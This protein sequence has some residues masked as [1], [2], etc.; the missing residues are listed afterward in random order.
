MSNPDAAAPAWRGDLAR[1]LSLAA[2]LLLGLFVVAI[3]VQPQLASVS[4]EAGLSV[5]LGLLFV[6]TAF[7]ARAARGEAAS[8]PSERLCLALC[9]WFGLTLLGLLRTQHAGEAVPQALNFFL[10]GLLL[11]GAHAFTAAQPAAQVCVARAVVALGAVEALYGLSMLKIQLPRLREQIAAGTLSLRDEMTSRLAQDRFH[12][13]EIY[14]S[15]EIANSF[16]AF[17]LVTIFVQLGLWLDERRNRQ[18]TVEGERPP[19]VTG[20]DVLYTGVLLLQLAALCQSGSKGAWVAALLG[21]WFFAAQALARDARRAKILAALT[22]C[23]VAALA[24]VLVLMTAGVLGASLL[25]ES[26]SMRIEYWRTA[27]RMVSAE[28]VLGIGLGSFGDT[29]TFFKTPLATETRQA[30][31]DWLQLWAE[32]GVLGPLAWGVLWWTALRPA[33]AKQTADRSPAEPSPDIGKLRFA[34]FAAGLAAFVLVYAVFD[35]LGSNDLWDTLAGHGDAYSPLGVAV[36]LL[37]P[38]LFTVVCVFPRKSRDSKTD[39]SATGL[40]WGIRAAVGAVLVHQLVD[41]DLRAPAVMAA[42]F[43][44]AGL[45]PSCQPASEAPAPPRLLPRL[46]IW[47]AA[48]LAL[49]LLPA[50]FVLHVVSGQARQM[51]T[52]HEE[53]L[54]DCTRRL[55]AAA[56]KAERERLRAA[57]AEALK[58]MARQREHALSAAPYDGQAAFDL[59]SA[60]LTLRQHGLRRWSAKGG[61]S[62]ERD[63]G[64]L[65]RERLEDALRLR[66]CWS[67]ARGMAGHHELNEGC[68]LLK[69]QEVEKA[70]LHFEAAAGHYWEGAR[71]YPHAP[72]FAMLAGDAL[73]FRNLPQD[74]ARAYAQGWAEDARIYDPNQRCAAVFHD[75]RPGCLA[76]MRHGRDPEVAALLFH[77]AGPAPAGVL[78]RRVLLAAR[79]HLDIRAAKAPAEAL[80]AA[81]AVLVK[82]CQDLAQAAPDDAH[83][84]LFLA[85]ALST[86]K[87]DPAA[88]EAWAKAHAL[89]G[90]ARAAGQPAPLPKVVEEL[91]CFFGAP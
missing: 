41:F 56:T 90:Q 88:R 31:N 91:R 5:L 37:L 53:E 1:A 58:N 33:S 29:F 48:A 52:A 64:D 70:A 25:G 12:S 60:Y 42:L 57:S 2:A 28:P 15:F 85:A 55:A 86:S 61:I 45:L 72:A 69:Q 38:V 63:L 67:I 4:V 6:L 21:L 3:T 84:A 81:D 26:F 79:E 75:S 34:F 43:L 27:W 30:H 89:I 82:T 7:G 50:A 10:F 54:L 8:I 32:L 24:G 80:R 35:S 51:A 77:T 62:K 11:L 13:E 19:V 59:A 14:G 17:L 46:F 22:A 73:L 68:E 23:G 71:H 78:A 18:S 40:I 87:N 9:L 76:A 39:L 16:A 36:A 44:L 47:A 74:A 66:P 20:G 49:A 83:A 65:V